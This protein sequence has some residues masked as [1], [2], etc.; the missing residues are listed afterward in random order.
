LRCFPVEF[1][2]P[3][4]IRVLAVLTEKRLAPECRVLEWCQMR[5]RYLC[6]IL[7]RGKY[8]YQY[9]HCTSRAT[10]ACART[11]EC[12]LL[13]YGRLNATER[14]PNNCQACER[15]VV[16]FDTGRVGELGLT[17]CLGLILAHTTR[18]E[19]IFDLSRTLV[20]PLLV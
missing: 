10:G 2:C 18:T 4:P 1:Q 14:L 17:I 12:G 19:I 6:F 8:Q 3:Y 13:L 15:Y 16:M 11:E 9:R 20:L 5:Y 7:L